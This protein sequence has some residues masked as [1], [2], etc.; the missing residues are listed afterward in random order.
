[1]CMSLSNKGKHNIILS[2]E[3]SKG[4]LTGDLFNVISGSCILQLAYSDYR[5]RYKS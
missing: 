4:R 2:R 3:N 1:M 5:F